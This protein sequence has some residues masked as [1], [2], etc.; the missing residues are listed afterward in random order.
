MLLRLLPV[1]TALATCLASDLPAQGQTNVP[2]KTF[3]HVEAADWESADTPPE[4]WA[5]EGSA[6]LQLHDSMGAT[7]Q[8]SPPRLVIPNV[9]GEKSVLEIPSPALPP[10][11]QATIEIRLGAV[12]VN[13]K[14]LNW[15]LKK[16]AWELRASNQAI[17]L[18]DPQT[19]KD[20]AIGAFAPNKIQTVTLTYNA[21][22]GALVAASVDG[23]EA[24]DFAP[25]PARG[26][27]SG[28]QMT[29]YATTHAGNELWFESLTIKGDEKFLANMPRWFTPAPGEPDTGEAPTLPTWEPV[30]DADSL[31]FTIDPE[32]VKNP[33]FQHGILFDRKDFARLEEQLASEPAMKDFWETNEEKA[34]KLLKNGRF[35]LAEEEASRFT[36]VVR[37]WLARLAM[38]YAATGEQ[39][40][41]QLVRQLILDL[42]DRPTY[43]WIHSELR[44]YDPAWPVGQLE[45]AEMT[46]SISLSLDWCQDLFSQEEYA[47]VQKMIQQKGLDPSLR[48][49]EGPGRKHKNNFLAVIGSGGLIGAIAQKDKAA[50]QVAI[51]TLE[52]WT[53]S[54]E[55]DGSYGEPQGYFEYGFSRFLF[56]WWALGAERGKELLQ[57][58]SLR[59]S[60]DWM[61][62]YFI[63]GEYDGVTSAWRVNFGDD[64]FLTGPKGRTTF[65]RLVSES[66]AYIYDDGL[67]T[68][69]SQNLIHPST[70]MNVYEFCFRLSRSNGDLPAPVSP[71]EKG[72]PLARTFDNGLAIIR[73]GWNFGDDTVFALRSGGAA[74]TGYSHDRPNRNAFLLFAHGD[75]LAIAPGRASYRNPIHKSWDIATTTHNTIAL[76]GENQTR[77]R[78]AE[79]TEFEDN[80]TWVKVAS[81]AK[82]SYKSDPESMLRTV[83]YLKA[84]DAF[85]IEDTIRLSQPQVPSLN[86]LLSNFNGES[87]LSPLPDAGWLLQRPGANL[88]LWVESDD[89][90]ELAMR[91]GYMHLGYSYYPGG[92]GEGSLGSALGLTWRPLDPV[93]QMHYYSLLIPGK[94]DATAE[95]A[96]TYDDS[97]APVWTIEKD[98]LSQEVSFTQSPDGKTQLVLKTPDSVPES[99]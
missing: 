86:I 65:T 57:D 12:P 13:G 32:R 11:P 6:K 20:V 54:V 1:V 55:P 66:L 15:F 95:V 90:L 38:L 39:H 84:L 80:D 71:Q 10:F 76:D 69:I 50:E 59:G 79:F 8:A 49:M 14:G 70:K 91:Q 34:R 9:E 45:C 51:D 2:D 81:Q 61:V 78:V 88:S 35:E 41:G 92:S 99:E 56:G 75:Y 98:G 17:F 87:Q 85:V 21:E 46:R 62:T 82:D 73:S 29:L 7:G 48:W 26:L 18:H 23:V 40:V 74:G 60:L 16:G 24:K 83:W 30:E 44:T 25:Y 19:D 31:V 53:T 3:W 64:D 4:G 5:Y 77:D 89:V 47:H 96:I 68:W 67:G 28:D 33:A 63:K 37:P 22:K 27:A 52:R 36:Y 58:K 94:G 93:E 42:A 43:F 72:L 97:Y